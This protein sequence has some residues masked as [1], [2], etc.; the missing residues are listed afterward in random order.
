MSKIIPIQNLWFLLL[1]ASEYVHEHA[2]NKFDTA[3]AD[4]LENLIGIV[5]VEHLD[6]YI[7]QHLRKQLR[8]KQAEL[9][10]VKGKINHYQTAIRQSLSKGR[11]FCSYNETTYNTARHA[12]MLSAVELVLNFQV[13]KEII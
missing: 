11:V 10:V 1:Y 7:Q 2:T 9:S 8:S 3:Q 6:D 5:L 13:E 4:G 12:Y